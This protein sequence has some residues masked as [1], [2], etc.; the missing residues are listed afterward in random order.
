M[1]KKCQLGGTFVIEESVFLASA[2]F[3]DNLGQYC[4]IGQR[5]KMKVSAS[6]CPLKSARLI[7]SPSSL[8]NVYEA[9][10]SFG[11]DDCAARGEAFWTATR[12]LVSATCEVQDTATK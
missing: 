10:G 7:C 12:D 2:K 5:V 3:F 8:V 4:G 9:E 11:V 6:A 1:E